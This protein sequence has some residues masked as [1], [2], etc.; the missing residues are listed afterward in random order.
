VNRFLVDKESTFRKSSYTIEPLA[1]D[2][3]PGFA[4]PML[5]WRRAISAPTENV[6]VSLVW[7]KASFPTT[8]SFRMIKHPDL[9]QRQSGRP[10]E[11]VKELL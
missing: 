9:I 8:K 7:E 11:N 3:A 5:S 1:N 6:K 10:T 2:R 4:A